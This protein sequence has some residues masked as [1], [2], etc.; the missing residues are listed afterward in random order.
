MNHHPKFR[1]IKKVL[2]TEKAK[3]TP[4]SND[5]MIARINL[6]DYIFGNY[7]YEPPIPVSGWWKNNTQR[8]NFYFRMIH[9]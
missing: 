2:L 4:T 8:E 9:E 3:G 7:A 6:H 1:Y 5:G